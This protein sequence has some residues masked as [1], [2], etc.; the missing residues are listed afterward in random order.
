MPAN[1]YRKATLAD[2]PDLLTLFADSVQEVNKNLYTE[3]QI[4]AWIEKGIS[5][6]K[7]WEDRVHEQYFLIAERDGRIVG[8]ASLRLDGYV[9]LLFVHKN[10][11]RQG[12]ASR[13]LDQLELLAVVDGLDSLTTEA[14]L[15]GRPFFE[16]KGFVVLEALRVK[17]GKE[18]L[19][20]F[21]MEKRLN[22]N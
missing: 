1:N 17:I 6:P 12:I 22:S 16:G 11:Q 20:N 10:F 19:P 9:D 14:S 5:N 18:S 21:K 4:K 3:P 8:F 13:L 2:I 7:R 15:S